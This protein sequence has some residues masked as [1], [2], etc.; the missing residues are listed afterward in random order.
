MARGIRKRRQYYSQRQV[1]L[2]EQVLRELVLPQIEQCGLERPDWEGA[3]VIG[4]AALGLADRWSD[5][6]TWFVFGPG[7]DSP[8]LAELV[9]S[10]QS[11]SL[12]AQPYPGR[13]WRTPTFTRISWLDRREARSPW[14]RWYGRTAD[15]LG[16]GELFEAPP[17]NLWWLRSGKV[18]HDPQGS[19]AGL[20]RAASLPPRLWA[21][22]QAAER[23]QHAKSALVLMRAAADSG[24]AP[25]A[26]SR[27]GD[28]VTSCL[29]AA[30]ASRNLVVPPP[31]CAYWAVTE[32]HRTDGI[33]RVA[34]LLESP[35]VS[36][37]LA[38]SEA[39]VHWVGRRVKTP[40]RSR[41][42]RPEVPVR[43]AP[44]EEKLTLAYE[45]FIS[46][47]LP[48]A[49]K[50]ALRDRF[51]TAS[52]LLRAAAV[53][54]IGFAQALEPLDALASSGITRRVE[55]MTGIVG[56]PAEVVWAQLDLAQSAVDL[57]CDRMIALGL[58]DKWDVDRL[59]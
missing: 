1:R 49:V 6:N 20:Q 23:F 45:D 2:G 33:E 56:I 5:L 52:I 12:S 31:H 26:W 25:L 38:R 21:E 3:M 55:Q 54:I 8:K 50:A 36:A 7:R 22:Q 16:F 41:G 29:Q 24:D 37:L 27:S 9:N 14:V 57:C 42:W 15:E 39:L 18:V 17:T 30:S 43:A 58:R 28:L 4:S 13:R 32:H 11:F 40:E 19:L 10:L 44:T 35:D 46:K 48:H 47:Y 51:E 59:W 53:G 34:A